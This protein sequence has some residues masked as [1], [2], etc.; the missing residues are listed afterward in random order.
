MFRSRH[1]PS[2]LQRARAMVW[3]K[4]GWKR[5]GT[6]VAHRIRR[7]PGSPY[8]IAAG[9]AC[10]VGISFTPFIGVHF[11]GAAAIAWLMGG[12]LFASAIGTVIG[13]PWTFPIIWV[14]SYKLGHFVLGGADADLP[15][16]LSMAYIFDNP[17]AVLL[18]MTVGGVPMG[19]AAWFITF[20]LVRRA[21]A[22]YQMMRRHRA[23]RR[24]AHLAEAATNM[25]RV[26]SK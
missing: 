4:S 9:F 18:P 20:W 17:G 2:S 5:A 25:E 16:Q 22:R 10:G 21:V 11:V 19:L 1:R 13:N 6:Y 7:L 14:T 3:P 26:G 12:N 23:E 8:S 15:D 24:K